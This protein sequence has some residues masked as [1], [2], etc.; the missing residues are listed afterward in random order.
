MS[1]SEQAIDERRCDFAETLAAMH[2]LVGSQ[3]SVC[4]LGARP[5]TSEAALLFSGRFERGLEL[6][7]RND[8]GV[9]FEI[10][11]VLLCLSERT[12]ESA[13]R[14]EYAAGTERWLAVG[15]RF[16]GGTEVELDQLPRL[17]PGDVL[18]PAE[19]DDS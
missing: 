16:R 1:P 15:L 2:E 3:V 4:V 14:G 12:L 6:G 11:G 10:G 9:G 8:D 17:E 18:R 5:R 19:E 7:P 13:W